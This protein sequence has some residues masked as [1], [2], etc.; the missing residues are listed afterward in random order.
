MPGLIC[1]FENQKIFE[2]N[3][4][5]MGHLHAPYI[6]TLRQRVARKPMTLRKMPICT[7]FLMP[8]FAS[9]FGPCDDKIVERLCEGC[10]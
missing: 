4:K 9:V 6:L 5:F 2:D 10:V 3:V 7:Q 1:K 8:S